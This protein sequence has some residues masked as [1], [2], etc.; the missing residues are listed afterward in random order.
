[1]N[2]NGSTVWLCILQ[3][4]IDIQCSNRFIIQQRLELVTACLLSFYLLLVNAILMRQ[5]HDTNA[6]LVQV[7]LLDEGEDLVTGVC[8]GRTACVRRR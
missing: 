2:K 6:K 4:N 3:K 7:G 5:L 1:M 8:G